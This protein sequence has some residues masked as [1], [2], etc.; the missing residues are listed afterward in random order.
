MVVVAGIRRAAADRMGGGALAQVQDGVGRVDVLDVA[1]LEGGWRVVGV[2]R[3][4]R[5]VVDGLALDVH[6]RRSVLQAVGSEDV[7]AGGRRGGL[8]FGLFLRWGCE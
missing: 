1:V 3:R 4:V 5:R 2:E 6:G 7:L 8:G